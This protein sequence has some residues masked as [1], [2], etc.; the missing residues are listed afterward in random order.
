MFQRPTRKNYPNNIAVKSPRKL[1]A[2]EYNRK[3]K[4]KLKVYADKRM[5]SKPSQI[6]EGNDVLVQN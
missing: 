2:S 4:N 6:E 3:V 1:V 5:H